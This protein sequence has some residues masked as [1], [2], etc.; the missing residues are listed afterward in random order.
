MRLSL[1][2]SPRL[3]S[4]APMKSGVRCPGARVARLDP[5]ATSLGT[6]KVLGNEDYY[7]SRSF[8]PIADET[9]N[10]LVFI[11]SDEDNRKVWLGKYVFE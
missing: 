6:F 10:S 5:A 2:V 8:Q 1:K 4:G 7:V 11:G 9:E 3:I